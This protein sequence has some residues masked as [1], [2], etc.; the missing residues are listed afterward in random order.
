MR[1]RTGPLAVLLGLVLVAAGCTGG[2]SGGANPAAS[3]D[4][5]FTVPTARPAAVLGPAETALNLVAPAGYVESGA[6]DKL[7]DW[8]TPFTKATGCRVSVAVASGPDQT[9]GLIAAGHYDGV[10]A[11]GDVAL[12]L[13][14]QHSVAPV[15][16]ALVPNYAGVVPGLR[17]KP[18]YTVGAVS[19]GVPQGRSA[20]VLTWRTDVVKAPPTSWASVYQSGAA[21]PGKITARDSPDTI[22]DG[23]VYLR[24]TRPELKIRN[25]YEL[26]KTQLDEVVALLKKQR[27][28]I[29]AY[30]RDYQQAVPAFRT[31]QAALGETNQAIAELIRL[32][33]A[34]VRSTVPAE[35]TTGTSTT[36]ML[37]AKAKH[38]NCMYRWMNQML[39]PAVNARSAE[40]LGIAPATAAACRHTIDRS[41]CATFHAT[42]ETFWSKVAMQTAP[43]IDCRDGRGT[44]CTNYAA[45]TAAWKRVV[46]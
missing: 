39:S 23:A 20:N 44:T 8:V 4:A 33:K 21:Y 22:A 10:A 37:A 25:P 40:W 19:Y 17:G 5:R 34:P 26:T 30:W 36:W 6:D 12:R 31:G 14:D 18:W 9:A 13:V 29:G 24:S 32:S 11:T 45:W 43:L 7:A 15:N 41:W 2:G 46:A 16:T 38:P 35:G 27:A 42:D 28:V 1:R 3:T